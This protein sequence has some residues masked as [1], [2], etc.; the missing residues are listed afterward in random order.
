MPAYLFPRKN[1]EGDWIVKMPEQALLRAEAAA[2]RPVLVNLP[3]AII[4]SGALGQ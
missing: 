3:V 2:F 4:V 1:E